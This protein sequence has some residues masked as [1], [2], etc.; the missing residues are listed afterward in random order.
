[1]SVCGAALFVKLS[2]T[3]QKLKF[4]DFH[5]VLKNLLEGQKRSQ[6]SEN[7]SFM[8]IG[9]DLFSAQAI[10]QNGITEAVF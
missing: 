1:M 5:K 4:L 7:I 6:G 9:V 2:E 8:G 3:W 10:K